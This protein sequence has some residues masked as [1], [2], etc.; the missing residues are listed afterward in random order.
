MIRAAEAADAPRICEIY[1]HYIEHT[2]VTF[3]ETSVAAHDIAARIAAITQRYPWLVYEANGTV[4]GYAYAGEWKQRSAYRHSVESTIYLSPD[5]TR[6]GIGTELYGALLTRLHG[7]GLHCAVGVIALPNAG[8]V[9]LHE[10]LGF[11]KVAHLAEIGWKL[12]RWV[13][14]GYWQR[15]L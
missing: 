3:E 4:A 10:R 11:K 1:N 14:V 13:D 15:A 6:R 12:G 7:Q 2:V 8:S 5:I 9:A